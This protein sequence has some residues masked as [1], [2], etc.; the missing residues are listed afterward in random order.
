[1]IQKFSCEPKGRPRVT[2]ASRWNRPAPSRSRSRSLAVLVVVAA[3]L[4]SAPA[5]ARQETPAP[6]PLPGE[7]ITPL[8]EAAAKL[9]ALRDPNAVAKRAREKLRPPYEFIRTQI[10]PFEVLTF[11]KERHWATLF[12]EAR[13]NDFEF[14]GWLQTAPVRLGGM[15]HAVTFRRADRLDG[16]NTRRMSMSIFLPTTIRELPLELIRPEAIRPEQG[17]SAFLRKLEPHQMLIVLAGTRA[18][19]YTPWS[20][21]LALVPTSGDPD[22][23]ALD[24]QRYY[25]LVGSQAPE[26]D[27]PP[28]AANPMTWSTISHVI[29]DDLDPDRL[30][31]AQRRA[32]LDWL[33][34]GGQ[35]IVMGG[36]GPSLTPLRDSFLG[37]YLPA[38][39]SGANAL[40]TAEDLAALSSAHLAPYRPVEGETFTNIGRYLPATEETRLRP[41]PGKPIVLT[42][43]D[44][45]ANDPDVTEIPLGDPTGKLLL[46]VERRV[47][48]G[49]ILMLAA[50]ITEKAWLDWPGID[51]LVRR[52]VLR[53]PEEALISGARYGILSGADLTWVRYTA[54]DQGVPDVSTGP[55]EFAPP[56]RFPGMPLTNLGDLTMPTRPVAAWVDQAAIPVAARV[57]LQNASGLSIP[58]R[59]FVLTVI[60]A[61]LAA[62][63]PVNWLVC[64][65]LLRRREL[66]WVVT[67]LLAFGFAGVVERGAARDQGF[68]AAC[69]EIDL[70]EING[71]YPRA[72]LSRFI[73][74]ATTGRVNV[75]VSFPAS[76]SPLALPLDQGNTVAG[77]DIAQSSWDSFPEPTLKDVPVPPRSLTMIRAEQM[78]DLPGPVLLERPSSGAIT[79]TNRTGLELRDAMVVRV[80]D[81]ATFRVGLLKPDQ[82]A[83][84]GE[85]GPLPDELNANDDDKDDATDDAKPEPEPADPSLWLAPARFLAML[86]RHREN[87]A[88][89]AGEWRLVAWVPG[90]DP[91]ESFGPAMDRHRGTRFVVAH[92]DYGP[93]PAFDLP[94]ESTQALAPRPVAAENDAP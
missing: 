17:T 73:G 89:E 69:D 12:V 8:S 87:N 7:E 92:L 19:D 54:R 81:G 55:S 23:N 26:K 57:A 21:M 88:V 51:S 31:D 9:K 35:L 86:A 58:G 71:R 77:S 34:W 48:R 67:P 62:L 61:Y 53:R 22:A 37:P 11:V 14:E 6:A 59:D 63:V 45:I 82:T 85:P 33:H 49:R 76:T 24:R 47:G 74:L 3:A 46:G 75:S 90:P 15:P 50:R 38:D 32:L 78:L 64:R 80:A 65:V 36:A 91:L 52:V 20:R 94:P 13:S 70:I 2:S 79:V 5:R 1:M 39:L 16:R 41:P 18:D 42:G 4:A 25:R 60:L 28:L 66:A 10:A 83:T 93:A 56:P 30:N 44:P 84:L 68:N 72:H 40:L 29:W 27:L 43:L